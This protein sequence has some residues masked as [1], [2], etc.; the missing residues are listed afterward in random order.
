MKVLFICTA[1]IQRSLTA[2]HVCRTLYPEHQ[3]KSAGVSKK[4]CARNNSTLC[5]S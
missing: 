1:N 4:E 3:F 5:T 2:E